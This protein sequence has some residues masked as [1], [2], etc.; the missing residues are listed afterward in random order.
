VSWESD[1]CIVAI[2]FC[3]FVRAVSIGCNAIFIIDCTSLRQ[4]NMKFAGQGGGGGGVGVGLGAALTVVGA[5]RN[6]RSRRITKSLALAISSIIF[7]LSHLCQH[8]YL[9]QITFSW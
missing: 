3:M 1:V 5:M 8:S 6:N 9:P 7:H 2:V 4:G